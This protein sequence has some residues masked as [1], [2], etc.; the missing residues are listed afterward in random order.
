MNYYNELPQECFGVLKTTGETIMIRKG[1]K[2]YYP[3]DALQW[4]NAD[5][6]NQTLGV[7]KAE[8]KAMEMGSL[9]GWDIP[10]TNPNIYDEDGRPKREVI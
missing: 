6:L 2:G 1:E 4:A 10:A 7:S 9:F 5:E 8:R 3:Q